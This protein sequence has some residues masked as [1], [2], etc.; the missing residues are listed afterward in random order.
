MSTIYLETDKTLETL[1]KEFSRSK[2]VILNES[3]K[4]FLER[5]LRE[6]K[7]EI[8]RIRGKYKVS[9]VEDFEELYK[10]GEV[11]EKDSLNDFQRLDHLE[12]KKDELEKLLRAN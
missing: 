3:L 12:F 2:E 8:F 1:S 7:S 9:S 6:I 4:F 10:R 5:K 11:D